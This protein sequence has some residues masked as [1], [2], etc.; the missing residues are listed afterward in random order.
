M[1]EQLLEQLTAGLD[2]AV[3]RRDLPNPAPQPRAGDVR[4]DADSASYVWAL[5]TRLIDLGYLGDSPDN[6]DAAATNNAFVNAATRFQRDVG[7]EVLKRDGWL[8][9]KSWRILQCLFSFEDEQEPRKWQLGIALSESPAVARAA[10]LRL[11]VMGFFDDWNEYKLNTK[12]DAT[13][14]NPAFRKAYARFWHFADELRLV[15]ADAPATPRLDEACLGVLFDHDG[16]VRAL[17]NAPDSVFDGFHGQIEAIA[18][19]ELW[20]QGYDCVPGPPGMKKRRRQGPRRR[21]GSSRT[22]PKLPG[23]IGDFWADVPEPPDDAPRDRVSASLFAAFRD[24]IDERAPE[25]NDPDG[26]VTQVNRVLEQPAIRESF[27]AAFEDLASRIWDGVKRMAKFIWRIISGALTT[28]SNLVR[29]LARFIAREARQFFHVVV[30]AVDIVQGGVDYLRCSLYPSNPP[31]PAIIA[32]G[33]DF[34]HYLFV[35]SGTAALAGSAAFESYRHMARCFDAACRVIAELV[36]LLRGLGGIASRALFTGPYGWLRAL[37]AVGRIRKAYTHLKDAVNLI[38]T[39][40]VVTG[41]HPRAVM[42]LDVA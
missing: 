17:S 19:I 8:G 12:T 24:L 11:W 2:E 1:P 33:A 29:N 13:L 39:E 15:P 23:V 3:E 42:R 25:L 7:G 21:L 32:R 41:A 31:A 16:I 36:A 9:P 14:V 35:E 37:L 20:L 10:Y 27:V 30:R 28:V 26:V 6:R 18:R 38:E 22:V 40:F 5:R 34:D 4:N